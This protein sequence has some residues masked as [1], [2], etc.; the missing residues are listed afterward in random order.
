MMVR[1]CCTYVCDFFFYRIVSQYNHSVATYMYYNIN[2]A[3]S[4]QFIVYNEYLYNDYISKEL[5]F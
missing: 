3:T 1:Q 4:S 5:Y 2:L